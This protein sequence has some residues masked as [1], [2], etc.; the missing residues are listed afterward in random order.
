MLFFS[1][2]TLKVLYHDTNFPFVLYY[3]ADSVIL[4]KTAAE[5]LVGDSSAAGELEN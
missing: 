4:N 3:Q 1:T 5:I 2:Q